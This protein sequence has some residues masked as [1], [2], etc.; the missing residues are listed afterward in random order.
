MWRLL[1]AAVAAAVAAN[2]AAF[3]SWV[4]VAFPLAGVA[5]TVNIT[6]AVV[7]VLPF[8]SFWFERFRLQHIKRVVERHSTV[9]TRIYTEN[10]TSK[11]CSLFVHELRSGFVLMQAVD[12]IVSLTEDSAEKRV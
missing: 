2:V 7:L 11:S 6:L 1:S 12:S 5:V 9:D 10:R 4:A 3:A 8:C